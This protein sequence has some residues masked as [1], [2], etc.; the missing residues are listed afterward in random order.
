MIIIFSK[1]YSLGI[2][3]GLFFSACGDALLNYD[4]FPHGMGAFGL[5]QICY[6][7]SFGFKPLKLWIGAILYILGITGL[8]NYN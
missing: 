1:R 5:A 3:L 7:A 6:I 4:L 2:F 8:F